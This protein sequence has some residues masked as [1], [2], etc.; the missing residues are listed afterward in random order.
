EC[1]HDLGP[2]PESV[3]GLVALPSSSTGSRH[4]P[5]GGRRAREARV[6]GGS[7]PMNLQSAP[8]EVH[9]GKVVDLFNFRTEDV[10]LRDIAR[11]LSNE[12]RFGNQTVF[13]SVGQHSVILSKV[14]PDHL[15]AAALLHD[16]AEAY[17]GDVPVP[18]K[19]H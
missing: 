9:S 6:S 17:L 8:L 15:A 12:S 7:D 14:V 2:G 10:D 11:G 18:L 3:E 19:K 13:Y 1:G 5:A 4:G 16:A